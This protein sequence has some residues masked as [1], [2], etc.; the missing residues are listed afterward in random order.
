MLQKSPKCQGPRAMYIRPGNN[1]FSKR[2]HLL[3]H[4]L[5]AIHL[6]LASFYTQNT[7]KK[8][9]REN[10]HWTNYWISI[11]GAWALWPYMYSYNC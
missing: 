7:F 1:M 5:I 4:F 11:E 8:I 3:Y 9:A 10:A 2:N 6:H